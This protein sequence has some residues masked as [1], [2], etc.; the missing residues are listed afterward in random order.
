MLPNTFNVQFILKKD[1]INKKGLAPLF[2]RIR[3]NG[4]K[5]EIT[6]NRSIVPN[7]WIPST[8]KTYPLNKSNK[9]LNNYLEIFKGKIF[10]AYSSLLSSAEE[11]C[12]ERFKE[13]LFGKRNQK[14][15]YLIETAREH[16]IQF[17]KLIGTKYSYGS[18]KNYKTTLKYL[19]EF[20]PIQYRI[21]DLL[22]IQADYKFC[23]SYFD[24][25][26]NTKNC[27][28]NGANKQIQ[29]LKKIINY[30]IKLGYVQSN[31][32]A[33]Y[34]LKFKPANRIALTV[35][36]INKLID[37]NFK[38]DTLGMVSSYSKGSK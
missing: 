23:E 9:E 33:S 24:Y 31:P 37:T 14:K 19:V 38:R 15:Y 6:T 30:G 8:E 22:L 2:A 26:I 17:E 25:L 7:Q 34:S 1:K 5:M 12:P 20:I 3:L 27:K 18:Y 10:S 35:E 29:R 13:I 16:N 36:E 28:T 11:V 4:K 21:K 32:M